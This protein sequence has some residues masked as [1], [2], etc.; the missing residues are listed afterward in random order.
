MWNIRINL[1]DYEI[2]IKLKGKKKYPRHNTLLF[3]LHSL[4]VNYITI[5]KNISVFALLG[6]F[7]Y[8]GTILSYNYKFS[9][10][11]LPPVKWELRQ[12]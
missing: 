1:I 8:T 6:I 12:H 7:K 9:N 10:Q 4:N 11:F 2:F 5:C 3:V